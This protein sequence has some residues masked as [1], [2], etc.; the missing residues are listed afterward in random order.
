ML[1][2]NTCRFFGR[3]EKNHICIGCETTCKLCPNIIAL[4]SIDICNNCSQCHTTNCKSC[5]DNINIICTNCE[6]KCQSCQK[7][8]QKGHIF[9]YNCSTKIKIVWNKKSVDWPN[10]EKNTLIEI[11]RYPVT[12]NTIQ[13]IVYLDSLVFLK[14]QVSFDSINSDMVEET[15]TFFK[16]KMRSIQF[17][18]N[19][20]MTF[21]QHFMLASNL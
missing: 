13:K 9:C 17:M 11:F 20:H 8:C 18:L 16:M 4:N 6:S 1:F 3:D 19:K 5:Y 15:E 12:M 10:S 2:C 7:T 21:G 14:K